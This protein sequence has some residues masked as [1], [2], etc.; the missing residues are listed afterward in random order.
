MKK[1]A[2]LN[3]LVL[4]AMILLVS[5]SALI[6][7]ESHWTRVY[8]KYNQGSGSAICDS[9][10]VGGNSASC[11]LSESIN[12]AEEGNVWCY[13]QDH[14]GTSGG[15]IAAYTVSW[16]SDSAD[17][18]CKAGAGRYGINFEPG[19]SPNCCG[20]DANENY[21]G[22]ANGKSCDGT[23]AACCN[24]SSEVSING[25]CVNT[26]GGCPIIARVY[27]TNLFGQEITQTQVDD[28]VLLVAETQGE[29]G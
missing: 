25:N 4:F 9:G 14:L 7:A 24:S 13:S 12:C 23:S 1:I 17:C 6:L 3:F 29:I 8:C 28:Y 27:W 16:D 2:R 22:P 18:T 15:P 10:Q 5:S 26:G 19:L 11:S 20:D 21:A